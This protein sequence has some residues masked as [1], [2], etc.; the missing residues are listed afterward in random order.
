MILER[1]E[2][3]VEQTSLR[4]MGET[5]EDACR[6]IGRRVPHHIGEELRV[7]VDA[8]SARA[9]GDHLA[10]VGV[11]ADERVLPARVGGGG[12]L[13]LRG[14]AVLEESRA[15]NLRTVT[16]LSSDETALREHN[17]AAAAA[18]CARAKS[19]RE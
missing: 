13:L 14:C 16:V 3:R 6:G 4:N 9:T 8:V 10:A 17:K 15:H 12:R 18:N 2:P 7:P 11:E 5:T 1:P 19:A